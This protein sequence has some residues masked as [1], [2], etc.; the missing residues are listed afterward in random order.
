MELDP[1][2]P[3]YTANDYFKE[4][5]GEKIIKITLDGGFTCP[6]RD[7]KLSNKGCI[8][9]STEGSG[10][11]T[12]RSLPLE[13]QFESMKEKMA[14]KWGYGKYMAYFQPFT[15]TY[16]SL[17]MLEAMFTRVAEFKDVCALSIATRPDCLE[18][19]KIEFLGALNKKLPVFVELGL[20]T[21]NENT[22]EYINRC[23]P[24]SVYA[25]AVEELKKENINIV[26]HIILGLP[27]EDIKD[28][29]KSVNFA[30]ESGT[31]GLKLQLLHILKNTALGHIYQKEKLPLFDIE[32]YTDTIVAL[33]ERIPQNIVIHRI[34]GDAYKPCI[35]EPRWS[36]DKRRVL[37]MISKKFLKRNTFQGRILK[38]KETEYE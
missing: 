18:K 12:K 31:D 28:M 4:V 2:H 27:G 23:Y 5:F 36:L 19:E 7:G 29:E 8:F 9:C 26:T 14:P 25:K 38:E 16:A 1:H 20:Q 35:I 17:P 37:N 21:S 3:L 34:T 24:N 11:Q 33:A 15:N 32:S 10:E 6:N 13:E 22:A 30:V